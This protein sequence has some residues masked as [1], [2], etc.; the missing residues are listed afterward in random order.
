[1][2]GLNI[3]FVGFSVVMLFCENLAIT[4]V[5]VLFSSAL[6]HDDSFPFQIISDVTIVEYKGESTRKTRAAQDHD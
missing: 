1:M 2:P 4:N 5:R 3:Y 6:R